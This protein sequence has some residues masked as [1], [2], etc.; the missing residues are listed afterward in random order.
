[1]QEKMKLSKTAVGVL[2]MFFASQAWANETATKLQNTCIKEQLNEHKEI[3]GHPLES[4]DFTEYCK[5]E[6]D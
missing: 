5:C 3:K 6:T 1:M 2:V 4:D